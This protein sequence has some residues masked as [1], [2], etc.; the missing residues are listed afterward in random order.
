MGRKDPF[1]T[2]EGSF[3]APQNLNG[4]TKIPLRPGRA[5]DQANPGIGEPL[6]CLRG[7]ILCLKCKFGIGIEGP[8]M[9]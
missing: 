5:R 8:A 9:V 4:I 2:R 7:P 6:L 1:Q 3:Y